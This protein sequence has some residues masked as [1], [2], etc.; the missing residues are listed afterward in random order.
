MQFSYTVK[1]KRFRISIDEVP[2]KTFSIFSKSTSEHRIIAETALGKKLPKRCVIHHIDK[3][4]KNNKNT[5]L[6]ICQ[7]AAYHFLLHQ[8]T[9]ALKA[10]GNANYR[11]CTICKKYDKPEN[12]NK[13][14]YHE[15]C[16]N[17]NNLKY[18]EKRKK[19]K[20][21]EFVSDIYYLVLAP[22][23]LK[24]KILPTQILPRLTY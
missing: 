7:D 22:I 23:F 4:K 20:Y 16:R 6:V 18:T 9:R 19:A 13:N 17:I 8:R 14:S 12:I 24:N 11:K 3:N 10:C 5:N 21:K 1:D 2:V 15:T